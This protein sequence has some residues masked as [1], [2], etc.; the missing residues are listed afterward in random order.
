[1][2]KLKPLGDRVLIKEIKEDKTAGGIFKPGDDDKPKK[3][4]VVG[5][6][7]GAYQNG[8]IPIPLSII[9]GDIVI[10]PK[11]IG[12]KVEDGISKEEYTVLSEKDI[13]IKVEQ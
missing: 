5:V 13:L 6:G 12:T 2:L 10:Y 3:G 9:E 1:M 4:V 8:M 7:P 11:F